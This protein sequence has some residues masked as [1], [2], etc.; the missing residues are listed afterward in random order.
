MIGYLIKWEIRI[1]LNLLFHP[2][3]KGSFPYRMAL[4]ALWVSKSRGCLLMIKINLD[5]Y[6]DPRIYL[7]ENKEYYIDKLNNT[8]RIKNPEEYVRQKFIEFLHDKMK[9]PYSA[10]KTEVSI[11]GS[12]KRM[13]IVVYGKKRS[14]NV[15]LLVVEL[16]SLDKKLS[17]KDYNQLFEYCELSHQK[18]AILSNGKYLDFFEVSEY[19]YKTSHDNL[20]TYN[21]LLKY[22]NAT[23]VTDEEYK[24]HSYG[25]LHYKNVVRKI[26]DRDVMSE[27]VPEELIAPLINLYE[28]LM[29][30]THKL[31]EIRYDNALLESDAGISTQTISLSVSVT[32]DYRTIYYK[33]NGQLD[34][35]Y[36][37]IQYLSYTS[38]TV[39]RIHNNAIHNSLELDLE[40]HA[41]LE[42]NYLYIKHDCAINTGLNRCTDKKSLRTYIKKHSKLKFDRKSKLILAKLDV[43]DLLYMDDEDMIEF[44]SNL[45]EYAVLRDE[46]RN[47]IKN[48]EKEERNDLT[49]QTSLY[50]F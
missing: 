48:I 42:D 16:K 33:L 21:K 46:Y 50:D 2:L 26:Y 12:A 13:D 45:I 36:I 3:E 11:T 31:P 23:K 1:F 9:V 34:V 4:L 8:L 27:Y 38:L 40:R 20:I 25:R 29:D 44:V 24:R 30:A 43:S 47:Y 49:I 17:Q 15:I 28:S 22:Y 19:D 37:T 39:S 32:S 6:D 41:A 5:K 14:K 7:H 18:L 10:M 35:I